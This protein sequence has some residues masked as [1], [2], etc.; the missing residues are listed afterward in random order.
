MVFIEAAVSPSAV[1]LHDN[2]AEEVV[3]HDLFVG[4]GGKADKNH[5]VI[6]CEVI[7][8]T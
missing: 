5:T 1:E 3:G 8:S 4:C 6:E 7:S 2:A